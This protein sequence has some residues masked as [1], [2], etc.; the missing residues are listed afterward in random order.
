MAADAVLMQ[1]SATEIARSRLRIL[2]ALP[3]EAN[4]P[5]PR[6]IRAVRAQA[7][8]KAEP[9]CRDPVAIVKGPR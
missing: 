1:G 4:T 9:T 3:V 7:P 6:L 2:D 5:T 8:D